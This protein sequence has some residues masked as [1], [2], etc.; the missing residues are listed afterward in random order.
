VNAGIG[1]YEEA[2]KANGKRYT[3]HM[4]PGAQHAFNNDTGAAR[5]NKE[6]ADLAWRRT[7]AFFTEHLGVPRAT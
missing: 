3:L 1:A 5:Y 7:V 2:L 4:Y 6:A